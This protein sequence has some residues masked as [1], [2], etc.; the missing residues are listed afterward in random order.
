L[1]QT[2]LLKRLVSYHVVV[3][4]ASCDSPLNGVVPTALAGN[5]LSVAKGVVTDGSGKKI[6][7]VGTV[8]ASNGQIFI[9]DQVLLPIADKVAGKV[10]APVAEKVMDVAMGMGLKM[11]GR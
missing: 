7:I 5:T 10:T 11:E 6:P 8:P 9:V 4:G 3:D 1:A 2:D